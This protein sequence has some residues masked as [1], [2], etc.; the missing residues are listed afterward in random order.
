MALNGLKRRWFIC[1]ILRVMVQFK[2]YYIRDKIY[3]IYQLCRVPSFVIFSFSFLIDYYCPAA[4]YRLV[5][6]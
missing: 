1:E 4:E 5:V 6:A 3:N 2:F